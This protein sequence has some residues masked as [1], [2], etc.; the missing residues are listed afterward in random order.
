ML[1]P[2]I[3][4]PYITAVLS[5]EELGKYNFSLS[6][7]NYFALIAGLGVSS[8]AIREGARIREDKRA[9]ADFANQMLEINLVSMFTAYIL[10]FC[11]LGIS[12]TLAPY[13]DLILFLSVQMLFT[14]IGVEWIYSIFEEYQYITIRSILFKIA[15]IILLFVLV[16][17]EGDVF[18]YAG[19]VMFATTGSNILDAF[20]ARKYFHF[21]FVNLKKLKKHIDKLK[22]V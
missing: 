2:L 12:N 13:K 8:Y 6:I 7:V 21:S 19:V 5:V 17:K 22:K 14:T 18:Q 1:F 3:T 20:F 4:Y 15:S 10:L 9:L 16:R 11:V